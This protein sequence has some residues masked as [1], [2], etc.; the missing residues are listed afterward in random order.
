MTPRPRPVAA[1]T[2]ATRSTSRP[3]TI[4]RSSPVRRP[5]ASRSS[6]T[7]RRST[8]SSCR[9]AAEGSSPASACG[10]RRSSPACGSSA[11]SPR[12]ARRCTPTSRP[13]RPT[14]CRSRRPWPTAWPATSSATASPGSCA[15]SSWT[16]WSLVEEDAIAD[17]MRWALEVPHILLEG[18]AVLGI[19]ALQPGAVDAAG[20]RRRGRHDRPQRDRRRAAR[21]AGMTPEEARR[22]SRTPASRGSRRSVPTARRTSCRSP[23]R[24]TATRIVT[25]VDAKPKRDIAARAGREHGGQPAGLGAGRPVRRRLDAPVV[26]ARRRAAR[27][28]GRWRGARPRRR[29]ASR[30][31]TRSTRHVEVDRAGH[32]HRVD[33]WS[34]WSADVAARRSAV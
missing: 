2:P 17:A 26:G 1:T 22:A 21:R 12:R 33:R 4:P 15:A 13:A 23:S 31:A 10:R 8:R 16:R 28:R 20:R 32:R 14:R 11:S 27:D 19:A 30:R 5:S 7:G 6:R 9:S 24:S 3:T 18:S 25:A 29:A 34:G